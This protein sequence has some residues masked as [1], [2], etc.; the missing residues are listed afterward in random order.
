MN[1]SEEALFFPCAGECLPGILARPCEVGGTRVATAG[2]DQQAGHCGVLIVVGGPQYRI[3]SHRQFLLLA[4]RLAGEGF[5]VMRFDYR[6]MGDGG[7][8]MRSFEEVD[9][10]IGAAIDAF[11]QTCPAVRSIVLW[12]LCDAASAALLYVDANHDKRVAGLVLLNPWVRSEVSL[13]Q[14]QIKHYYGQRLLQGE[15]WRKLLKGRVEVRKSLLGLI[16]KVTMASRRDHAPG[17]QGRSFQDRMAGGWRQFSGK[18]LLILSGQ[19]YV[20]KEF[21]EY[22]GAN[23]AW[24]GLLDGAGVHRVDIADADHTFSSR[25]QRAQ[26]ENTTLA[27]L[28]SFAAAPTSIIPAIPREEHA[29]QSPG[30]SRSP[31]SSQRKWL[32]RSGSSS[33]DMSPPTAQMRLGNAGERSPASVGEQ[34]R[35]VAAAADR[36]SLL[37]T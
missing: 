26:V 37:L 8:A 21:L 34:S 28:Q 23:R 27:W 29:R 2:R 11:Q 10:D 4:R 15:F 1:V 19:D 17:N 31:S 25:A 3:G 14:T 16:E 5:P 7:G 36:D 6:G 32:A 30:E 33:A 9:Q 13:A 20:A 12:G 24:S 22:V 35:M 18:L